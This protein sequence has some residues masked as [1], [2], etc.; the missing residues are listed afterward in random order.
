M[1]VRSHV[2]EVPRKEK[3]SV[4]KAHAPRSQ[5][6]LIFFFHLP[7]HQPRRGTPGSLQSNCS[8]PC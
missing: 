5:T 3:E 7:T 8:P 1:T 2:A 6:V 4:K